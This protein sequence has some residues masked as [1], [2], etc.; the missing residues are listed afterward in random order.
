VNLTRTQSANFGLGVA[1]G[2]FAFNTG[3]TFTDIDRNLVN[4]DS[5]NKLYTASLGFRPVFMP[6]LNM[7]LSLR[8]QDVEEENK[9]N[10]YRQTEG[11]AHVDYRF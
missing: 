10:S 7:T 3:V 8:H 6:G 2:E 5:L 9:S 1:Q 4:A 11:R